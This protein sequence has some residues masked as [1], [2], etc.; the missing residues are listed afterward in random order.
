M[1]GAGGGGGGYTVKKRGLGSSQDKIGAKGHCQI[2]EF[3][4]S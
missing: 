3:I 4:F 1:W 2:T